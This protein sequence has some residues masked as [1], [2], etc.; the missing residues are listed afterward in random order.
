[1]HPNMRTG[2]RVL[3]IAL[4]CALVGGGAWALLHGTQAGDT[5]TDDLMVVAQSKDGFYRADP[6]STD[7]SYTITTPATGH[8]AD[9]DGGANVVRIEHGQVYVEA[10]NCSN[11]VCVHHD[12]IHESGEQ[13]VC[14]PHGV[15][16]EVVAHEEDAAALQ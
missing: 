7:T 9:A 14:L 15:V 8:G 1:M 16:V 5:G 10:S 3:I 13:I 4:A 2:D 6:L 12:P 11:Q